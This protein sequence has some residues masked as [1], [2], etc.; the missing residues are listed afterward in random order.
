MT[1]LCVSDNSLHLR[2]FFALALSAIV[3][4]ASAAPVSYDESSGGD[5][6]VHSVLPIFSLEIGT[7]TIGGTIGRQIPFF[8]DFDSF[9]FTIPAGLRLKSGVVELTDRENDLV[10]V[11]WELYEGATTPVGVP[12]LEHIRVN[13]PGSSTVQ[14]R[15]GAGTFNF[16][17]VGWTMFDPAP[18]LSD[19]TF[20]LEVT[21]IPEPTLGAYLIASLVGLSPCRWRKR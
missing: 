11:D 9:A 3:A 7:N 19:Y 12:R 6:P 13:S 4:T 15:L 5:F 21:A 14:T 10:L 8:D 2:M 16:Y 18:A 20:T 17:S 1:S